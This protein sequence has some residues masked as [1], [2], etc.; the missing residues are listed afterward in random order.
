[1]PVS[2]QVHLIVLSVAKT[3]IQATGNAQALLPFPMVK[4]HTVACPA[5]DGIHQVAWQWL[6][7]NDRREQAFDHSLLELFI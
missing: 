2:F 1:M 6:T 3:S 4:T 5:N 7:I